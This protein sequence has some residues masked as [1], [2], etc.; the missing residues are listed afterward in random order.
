MG[1]GERTMECKFKGRGAQDMGWAG[2]RVV[3]C[4]FKGGGG[5]HSLPGWSQVPPPFL[6]L[7]QFHSHPQIFTEYGLHSKDC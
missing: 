4:K 1:A 2:E 7:Q 6:M 3:R 5:E